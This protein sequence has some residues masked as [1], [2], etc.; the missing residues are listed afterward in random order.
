MRAK[1]D[2]L[3]AHSLLFS[4]LPREQVEKIAGSP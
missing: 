1:K 3:L 2:E 4:G